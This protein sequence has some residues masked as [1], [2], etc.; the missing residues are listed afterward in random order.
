MSRYTPGKITRGPT[1]KV[2][3]RGVSAGS[4]GAGTPGRGWTAAEAP[5][6]R[7]PTTALPVVE[8]PPTT[9]TEGAEMSALPVAEMALLLDESTIT[10]PR[11]RL[12][13]ALPF[14]PSELPDGA[15]THSPQLPFG[16]FAGAAWTMADADT[17]TGR[18][19]ATRTAT[20]SRDR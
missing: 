2:T 11:V 10:L 17:S 18:V 7:L 14:S 3:D 1:S 6:V 5:V 16:W 4:A 15:S 20:T 13:T 12:S 9:P 8:T 19:V